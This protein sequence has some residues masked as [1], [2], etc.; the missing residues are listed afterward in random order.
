MAISLFGVQGD[1]LD[2][3]SSLL[4]NEIA[5]SNH[6]L[7]LVFFLAMTGWWMMTD[8]MFVIANE[9]QCA[10]ITLYPSF[11]AKCNGAWESR[12]SW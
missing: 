2:G 10:D 1:S 6:S 3:M 7:P 4:D 8:S 5:T 9:A 12:E 11:R